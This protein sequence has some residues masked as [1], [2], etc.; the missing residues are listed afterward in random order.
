MVK[1]MIRIHRDETKDW[2]TSWEDALDDFKRIIQD[3]NTLEKEDIPF[4]EK[5]KKLRN[6]QM[7]HNIC[8]IPA[9]ILMNMMKEPFQKMT[10]VT[11]TLDEKGEGVLLKADTLEVYLRIYHQSYIT[12]QDKERYLFPRYRPE[13]PEGFDKVAY[14]YQR[15]RDKQI[16]RWGFMIELYKENKAFR[17]KKK[18]KLSNF[19]LLL[20][21]IDSVYFVHKKSFKNL[22]KILEGLEEGKMME[23][24]NQKNER[25]NRLRDEKRA[26][27]LKETGLGDFL[28]ELAKSGN[29]ITEKNF[30]KDEWGIDT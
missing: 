26:R 16:S 19:R 4:V 5:F 10:G 12:V 3:I 25:L 18:G 28:K 20:S 13:F 14:I 30:I 22:E 2:A 24:E 8:G 27:V 11:M 9:T 6:L 29:E 1:E 7:E 15:Y 17:D 23:E 21:A